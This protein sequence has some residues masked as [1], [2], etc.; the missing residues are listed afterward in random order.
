MLGYIQAYAVQTGEREGEK[1]M[2]RQGRGRE[3]RE[4]GKIERGG[5]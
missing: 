1:E 5:G 2:E 3:E 4:G